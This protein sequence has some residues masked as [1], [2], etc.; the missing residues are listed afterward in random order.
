[1]FS[2]AFRGFHSNFTAYI[3]HPPLVLTLLGLTIAFIEQICRSAIV[4]LSLAMTLQEM[5]RFEGARRLMA[6][7]K[8]VFSEFAD[9]KRVVLSSFCEGVLLQRMKHHRE[10]R[11]IYFL[12]LSSNLPIEL[13]VLAAIHRAI[14]FAMAV[15]DPFV[16][17]AVPI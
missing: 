3:I 8:R 17:T 13:S 16:S 11:E 6:A 5:E 4:R 14:G 2:R 9:A 1:M 12:L 7:S 10:A 15:Q